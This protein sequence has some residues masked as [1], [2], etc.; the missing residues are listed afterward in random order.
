MSK[1]YSFLQK[2]IVSIFC[3]KDYKHFLAPPISKSI[4][5]ILILSM[6]MSSFSVIRS[7]NDLNITFKEINDKIDKEV[8]EF[9]IKDGKIYT[10]VKLPVIVEIKDELIIISDS[11]KIEDSI[12]SKYNSVMIITGKALI[13]KDSNQLKPRDISNDF[14]KTFLINTFKTAKYLAVFGVLAKT[15]IN[16][17][18]YILISLI[19]ALIGIVINRKAK[20]YFS[21]S[22]LLNL[23]LYAMTLPIIVKSV[24]EILYIRSNYYLCAVFYNYI[25]ILIWFHLCR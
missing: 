17:I 24:S 14:N 6:V 19:I 1:N 9:S 2:L 11:D 25:N 21:Y 7:I 3:L 18:I 12:M 8:P 10:D 16:V 5:Y 13:Q 15:L 4:K 23:S 22:E 20:T